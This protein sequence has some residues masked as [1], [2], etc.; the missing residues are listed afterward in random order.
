MELLYG[1]ESQNEYHRITL[2]YLNGKVSYNSYEI[3][4]VKWYTIS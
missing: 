1:K 2:Q 3:P 4:L